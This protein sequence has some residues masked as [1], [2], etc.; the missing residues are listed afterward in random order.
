MSPIA[1][2]VLFVVLFVFLQTSSHLRADPVV[3][4]NILDPKTAAEAWNVIQL[5]TGNVDSLIK[6]KRLTEIAVQISFC[7]PS[8]RA[9][10]RFSDS[11]E[12]LAKIGDLTTHAQAWIIE[13]AR[14]GTDNNLAGTTEAFGK[15]RL[16]LQQLGGFFDEKTVHADIWFCPMHPTFVSAKMNAPC[17]LCGMALVKR[18]I[19]YSFIYMKPGTPSIHMTATASGPVEADKKL[20]IKVRLARGDQSPVLKDDLMV[21]HTQPIHLLIEDPSLGDYHH[22]HPVPT[23]VPGEYAFS[24][25]PKKTSPYRI[26]A[27]IVPMATGVQELPFVDLPSPGV[28]G[29]V[30]DK[31]ST[32]TSTAGGLTFALTLANGNH[33]PP[34]AEQVCSMNVTITE[35]D[36][37]PATRL[38]PVMNAFAHLVGFYNDYSTVVHVHPGGGDVLTTEARGGPTLPFK[39]FPPKPGFIRFYCQVMVNGEMIFAPFNM[40]VQP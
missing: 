12:A 2:R 6:E 17:D 30:K 23:S 7:S 13:T 11:P 20:E 34:R 35:A 14:A 19:P 29:P 3:P 21:M 16:F 38:E 15:V 28:A 26:W 31:A 24:F 9:L 39:F 25:T 37:K 1:T 18:R 27:D 5:A 22:E 40:N 4:G 32:F 36:G 8:L 10:T 33:V